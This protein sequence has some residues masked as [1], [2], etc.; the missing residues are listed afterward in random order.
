LLRRRLQTDP[1][2]RPEPLGRLLR[3]AFETGLVP[4]QLEAPVRDAWRRRNEI[5]HTNLE[6][7]ADEAEAA[8]V[9]VLQAVQAL[10]AAN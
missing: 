8:V 2:G 5:V 9:A 7:P 4:E 6:V 3:E 10:R 1:T